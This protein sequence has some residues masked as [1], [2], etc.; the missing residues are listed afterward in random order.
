MEYAPTVILR[1]S[2]DREPRSRPGWRPQH[3]LVTLV[4]KIF[5]M[6]FARVYPLYLAKVEKK[7]RSKEE[8][9]LVLSWL[10]GFSQTELGN[11]VAQGNSFRAFFKQARLNPNADQITGVICGVRIEEIED[12]LMKKIRYMDKVVDELAKGKPLEKILRQ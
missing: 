4:H 2:N 6:A 12:P 1:I 10:T 9:D 8:L 3:R 11:Q 7:G 5:D